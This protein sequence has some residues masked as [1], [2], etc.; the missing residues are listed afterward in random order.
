MTIPRFSTLS[1]ALVAALPMLITGVAALANPVAH[2]SA[3][4]MAPPAT[5]QSGALALVLL[6]LAFSAAALLTSRLAR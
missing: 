6:G 1:L 4:S 3:A 5:D 2:A